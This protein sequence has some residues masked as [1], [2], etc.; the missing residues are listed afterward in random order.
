MNKQSMRA[1]NFNHNDNSSTIRLGYVNE[2]F[3]Y[4]FTTDHMLQ[5]GI[6]YDIWSEVAMLAGK[7]ITLIQSDDYG[8]CRININLNELHS[9]RLWSINDR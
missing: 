3:P 5:Q 8:R 2:L 7:T 6:Y 9:R 1:A 4:L